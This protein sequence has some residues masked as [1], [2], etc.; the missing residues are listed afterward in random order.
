MIIF[1]CLNSLWL[2][3]SLAMPRSV[4]SSPGSTHFTS[5]TSTFVSDILWM[6]LYF[7]AH[8]IYCMSVRPGREIPLLWLFIRFL[9][10]FFFNLLKGCFFHQCEVF[11]HLNRGSEDRECCSLHGSYSPLRQCDCEFGLCSIDLIWFDL[12]WGSAARLECQWR[13][14]WS[15][16]GPD[17]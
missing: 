8:D 5:T 4:Q 13:G 2:G 9:P 12:I 10:L 17:W 1:L 11:P 14:C 7:C 6:L 15:V 16:L 3:E